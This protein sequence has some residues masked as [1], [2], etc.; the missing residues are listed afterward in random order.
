MGQPE[1]YDR[2][3]KGEEIPQGRGV[4]RRGAGRRIAWLLIPAALV[5]AALAVG[6]AVGPA[7]GRRWSAP[8]ASRWAG[9]EWR[10][11][12]PWGDI[13]LDTPVLWL[14][15]LAGVV[16]L[17]VLLFKAVSCFCHCQ[18][19]PRPRRP[20][21]VRGL[22]APEDRGRPRAPAAEVLAGGA[23][24]GPARPMADSAASL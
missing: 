11:A 21:R 3:A 23:A 2:R 10:W 16:A 8:V 6:Q 13:S 20:R 12:S 18:S 5:A 15:V 1:N 22:A 19:R 14:A 4:G 9:W 24:A 17:A 7:A